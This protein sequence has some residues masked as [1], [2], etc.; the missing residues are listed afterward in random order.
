M[1]KIEKYQ[2]GFSCMRLPL[3]NADDVASFDF[4]KT[5]QLFD[6]YLTFGFTY[7]DT[8]YTYHGY[9]CEKTVRKALVERHPRS[10]FELA[11]KM[12]LRDFKDTADLET[13]F[14]EQR[15][16]CGVDYF[17]YYLLHN[18][19]TNVYE[20]CRKYGAFDFIASKFENSS[21]YPQRK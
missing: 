11:T 1:K 13:I 17:D 2:F 15:T 19:G 3:L 14:N 16:N 7:F 8:A 5:E 21:A 6:A 4:A 20:K 12:P 18:M 9:Q 10:A